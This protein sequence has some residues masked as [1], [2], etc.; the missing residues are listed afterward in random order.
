[1]PDLP[2]R[3]HSASVYVS[4]LS[5]YQGTV[6]A[7]KHSW[8][9]ENGDLLVRYIRAYIEATQWC[10]NVNNRASCLELL[11]INNGLDGNAAEETLDALL[12]PRYCMY[13]KATLNIPGVKA[14]IELRTEMGYLAQPTPPVQEY[15]D[16][17]FF[18][19]AVEA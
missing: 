10:F 12:D 11:A 16:L 4:L 8:A 19:R 18:Y 3:H 15:I 6:G 13:P 5:C 9:D 17:S 7:A 2:C 14:V 1:M